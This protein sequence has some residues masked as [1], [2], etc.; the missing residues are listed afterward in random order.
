MIEV[1][2]NND[3]VNVSAIDVAE[4]NLANHAIIKPH[5]ARTEALVTPQGSNDE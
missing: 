3:L 2:T 4:K 1:N 5:N